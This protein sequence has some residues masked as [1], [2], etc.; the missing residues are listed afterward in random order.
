[1]SEIARIVL[2]ED[3]PLVRDGLKLLL[4]T[5]VGLEVVG[6]TGDGAAVEALVRDT[7]PHLLVLDL[8][9]P[10]RNGVDIAAA[11]KADHGADVKVLILTGDLRPESVGRALAAGAN[12]YVLKTEDSGELLVAVRA[13]LAGREYVSRRIA[14]AFRPGAA[15]PARTLPELLATPREREIMS[16]VARGLANRDIGELLGIS[17]LTVR[18]HRQ[19]LME[20]FTLRNA[21]EI[22]AYAVKQ[23]FY[24]PA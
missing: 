18:T 8:D 15:R 17:V 21:A 9:L 7:S 19:N 22:T 1:M 4:A 20:K 2:A 24:D 3:H 6:E 23:G 14:D 16:L 13:V 5:E 10:G 12:G 11:V